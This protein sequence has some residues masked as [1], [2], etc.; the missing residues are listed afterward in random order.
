MS[1]AGQFVCRNP[2]GGTQTGTS[3]FEWISLATKYQ[4]A[5]APP[6]PATKPA[7]EKTTLTEPVCA[8]DGVADP[9]ETV[10][11]IKRDRTIARLFVVTTDRPAKGKKQ[12]QRA[13][14]YSL[15]IHPSQRRG[16]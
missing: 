16:R 2:E 9:I 3:Y 6:I 5:V 8:W 7:L 15:R 10:N 1:V 4:E 11:P 14:V 13:K 12:R